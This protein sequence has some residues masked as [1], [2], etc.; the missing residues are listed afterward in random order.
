[1]ATRLY[2]RT[3]SPVV[4]CALAGVPV[5][6]FDRMNAIKATFQAE[7]DSLRVAFDAIKGKSKVAEAKRDKIRTQWDFIS[8][9]EWNALHEDEEVDT[10]NG[11]ISSGFGR[12]CTP[13]VDLW[14]G[15]EY[16]GVRRNR[17]DVYN[18]LVTSPARDGGRGSL[19]D[20]LK[21]AGVKRWQLQGLYWC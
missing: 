1:M 19:L 7:H 4:L 16:C 17:R 12:L 6:T 9:R 21:R 13:L 18:I 2:A 14:N 3:T 20:Q 15:Q 8:E 10:L 11:F 5:A